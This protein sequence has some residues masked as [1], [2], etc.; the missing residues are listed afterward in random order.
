MNSSP[1]QQ[2][3]RWHYGADEQ[4]D[5][6]RLVPGVLVRRHTEPAP[7]GRGLDVAVPCCARLARLRHVAHQAHAWV[8]CPFCG[9]LYTTTLIDELDGG[10]A[11]LLEVS[12]EQVALARRRSRAGRT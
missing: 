4:V 3:S 8:G 2:R 5:P 12:A 11:A 6:N 1:S 7:R 9:L 10:Y